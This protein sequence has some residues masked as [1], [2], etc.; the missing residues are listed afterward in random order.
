MASGQQNYDHDE[1]KEIFGRSPEGPAQ[2]QE[3]VPHYGPNTCPIQEAGGPQ[4]QAD[5]ERDQVRADQ[6]PSGERPLAPRG[7]RGRKRKHE[8]IDLD[9]KAAVRLRDGNRCVQCGM[10][11]ALHI[12]H[13]GR[14]LEVHRKIPGSTYAVEGCELLCKRCH[15]PKPKSPRGSLPYGTLRVPREL[16]RKARI[17]ALLEQVK[18]NH[19]L[20][21][22]I[23]NAVAS[24]YPKLISDERQRLDDLKK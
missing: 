22:V 5:G 8:V 24:D 18:V 12:R 3:D 14:D 11:S 15:G 10:D 9:I 16:F 7:R 6:E 19:Y 20:C 13:Y 1:E 4:R 21:T 23:E 2:V 17:I